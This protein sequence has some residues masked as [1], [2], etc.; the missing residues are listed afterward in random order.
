MT[1][2]DIKVYDNSGLLWS[3][4]DTPFLSFGSFGQNIKIVSRITTS[5]AV[6][7]N[8]TFDAAMFSPTAYDAD[9]SNIHPVYGSAARGFIL[10]VTSLAIST[11]TQMLTYGNNNTHNIG[12]ATIEIKGASRQAFQIEHEFT[13]LKDV[14]DWMH[15]TDTT[16]LNN[17]DALTSY[18]DATTIYDVIKYY[19]IYVWTAAEHDSNG[20]ALAFSREGEYN[21]GTAIVSDIEIEYY[22]GATLKDSLLSNVDTT[23]RVKFDDFDSLAF[24]V[25][26]VLGSQDVQDE[27][28]VSRDEQLGLLTYTTTT[29]TTIAGTEK[30]A[31]FTISKDDLEFKNYQVIATIKNNANKSTSKGFASNL[32]F[33]FTECEPKIDVDWKSYLNTRTTSKID[34]AGYERMCVELTIWHDQFPTET[35]PSPSYEDCL[36]NQL[37]INST[38]LGS[39]QTI[40]IPILGENHI[41]TNNSGTITS[42]FTQD[43]IE[44]G[45][46]SGNDFTK[47]RIFFRVEESYIGQLTTL[48]ASLYSVFNQVLVVNG[49][50]VEVPMVGHTINQP[51]EIRCAIYEND[52]P[53]ADITALDVY[54]DEGRK[55]DAIC[56]DS[57]YI[58]CIAESLVAYDVQALLVN[59]SNIEEEELFASIQSESFFATLTSPYIYDLEGDF[60]TANNCK[61]KVQNINLNYNKIMVVCCK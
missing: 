45:T 58:E 59:P 10:D 20:A 43:E 46:S 18:G 52:N 35:P 28:N 11:P 31:E 6:S 9:P 22:D 29:I 12:T 39:L 47:I 61:F 50:L 33:S 14:N 48:D 15:S 41:F 21:K 51:L 49:A 4:G 44:S 7:G 30:Y 34:C 5:A 53:S 19:N 38:L 1:I 26:L 56:D 24:R 37:I 8:L 27:A 25:D 42:N 2:T 13:L 54:D 40:T 57:E 23:V 60:T 36:S 3:L 55:Y 17:G 16:T 32:K